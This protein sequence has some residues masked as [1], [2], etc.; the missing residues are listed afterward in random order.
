MG[1]DGVGFH[2]WGVF[3]TLGACGL[4]YIPLKVAGDSASDILGREPL[5]SEAWSLSLKLCEGT[6]LT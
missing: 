2:F 1:Q 4:F 6:S 5:L 3:A